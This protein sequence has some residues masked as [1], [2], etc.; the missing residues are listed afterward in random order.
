LVSLLPTS[1]HTLYTGT[2]IS[3][4]RALPKH[5]RKVASMFVVSFTVKPCATAD[6]VQ[7]FHIFGED[8]L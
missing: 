6:S 2:N 4:Q 3:V 7:W 8:S 5:K 1:V